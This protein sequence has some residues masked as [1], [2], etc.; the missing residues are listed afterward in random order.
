VI[1]PVEVVNP[2]VDTAPDDM[3]DCNG[4]DPEVDVDSDDKS[5]CNADDP[6]PITPEV[7]VASA[8]KSDCSDDELDV[9]LVDLVAV[10][11]PIAEPDLD[12]MTYPA[13]SAP[14]LTVGF[15]LCPRIPESF[16]EDS[17]VLLGADVPA[18]EDPVIV[19]EEPIVDSVDVV[20]SLLTS[21]ALTPAADACNCSLRAVARRSLRR[22]LLLTP[23]RNLWTQFVN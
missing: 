7:D 4:V 22:T 9:R 8:D 17:E 11:L 19:D 16:T 15:T 14:R 20:V 10:V 1:E 21:M 13:S 18:V 6:E 23:L 2:G 5:D 3:S 12:T